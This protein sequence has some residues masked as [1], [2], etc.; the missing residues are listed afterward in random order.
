MSCDDEHRL[1]REMQEGVR[2]STM[3]TPYPFQTSTTGRLSLSN[4]SMRPLQM[5]EAKTLLVV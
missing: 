2:G 3:T 4:S 5:W 1:A